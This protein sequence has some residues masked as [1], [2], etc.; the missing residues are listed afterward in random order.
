MASLSMF[1]WSSYVQYFK[2][3]EQV[4]IVV[5]TRY[6]SNVL[7]NLFVKVK[8]SKQMPMKKFKQWSNSY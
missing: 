6:A 4:E 8:K 5:F 7:L 2:S 1:E 3:Y